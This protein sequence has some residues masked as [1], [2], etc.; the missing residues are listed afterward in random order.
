MAP[1]AA[2]PDVRRRNLVET[3]A[4]ETAAALAL[5]TGWENSA[6]A[7]DEPA[8]APEPALMKMFESAQT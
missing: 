5:V 1:A 2:P 4:R 8:S 3:G 6:H 7:D